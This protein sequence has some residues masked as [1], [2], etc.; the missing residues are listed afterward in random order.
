MIFEWCVSAS[1]VFLP[2][3]L[4]FIYLWSQRLQCYM[5]KNNN[6]KSNKTFSL[7]IICSSD[8][9]KTKYANQ[10]L[11]LWIQCRNTETV[12]QKKE[13]DVVSVC[14]KLEISR[15]FAFEDILLIIISSHNFFNLCY[16]KSIFGV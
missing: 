10:D 15:F 12:F 6:S 4:T 2:H 13:Y 8:S 11:M 16:C 5:C 9:I 14:G 3:I 7:Q 1:H